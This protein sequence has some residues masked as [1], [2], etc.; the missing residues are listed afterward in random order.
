MPVWGRRFYYKS[1]ADER[2]AQQWIAQL[3]AYLQSIQN[4]IRQASLQ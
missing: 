3:V 2:R 4:P 1:G